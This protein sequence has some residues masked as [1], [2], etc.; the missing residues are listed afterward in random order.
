MKLLYLRVLEGHCLPLRTAKNTCGPAHHHSFGCLYCSKRQGK[1]W[2]FQNI[3][4]FANVKQ[5]FSF[6]RVLLCEGPQLSDQKPAW[7]FLLAG[8]AWDAEQ[9]QSLP[10]PRHQ[11]QLFTLLLPSQPS[12]C[13]SERSNCQP[14]VHAHLF[15]STKGLLPQDESVICFGTI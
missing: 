15:W 4:E 7:L 11:L 9:T 3:Q 13:P 5:K 6:P 8:V 2:Q 14:G 12:S 10:L 1:S